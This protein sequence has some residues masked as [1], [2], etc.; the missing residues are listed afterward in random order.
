MTNTATGSDKIHYSYD[1]SGNLFSMN[2]NGTEY[3]YVRNAQGDITGLIDNAGNLVVSYTYDTWGKLIS[4]TGS[5]AGTLGVKNPY[6]YRGYRYD[7]ETGL[8]YL[9]SRYYSPEWGR[10]VNADDSGIL[11]VDQ[12]SLIENNLFVYALNNPV[13]MND[14]TG[15]IAANIAAGLVGAFA[16]AFIAGTFSAATQYYSTGKI[17]KNVVLINAASGAL[18]GAL[19]A[20]GATWLASVAGNAGISMGTYISENYYKGEAITFTGLKDSA[21]AGALSGVIGGKGANGGKM[22]TAA[23]SAQKSIAR[24][25]RRANQKYAAK[26]IAMISLSQSSI[27]KA[28]AVVVARY[29]IG[30]YS[31]HKALSLR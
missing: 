20:S 8:Y 27:K 15:Q 29:M 11:E 3:Y 2:L 18:S 4:T 13:N 24:E 28:V 7:T 12:D 23:K 5:L 22:I 21:F 14:S 31:S 26:Q 30:T 6:R 1:A 16:G 25:L 19:T 10:F 9:Q 17:D